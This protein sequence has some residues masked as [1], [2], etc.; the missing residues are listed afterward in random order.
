MVAPQDRL[1]N[2]PQREMSSDAKAALRLLEA[3]KDSGEP[4]R[5]LTS[6]HGILSVEA[7]ELRGDKITVCGTSDAGDELC[8]DHVPVRVF[9]EWGKKKTKEPIVEPPVPPVVVPPEGPVVSP[10][11]TPVSPSTDDGDAETPM[12]TKGKKTTFRAK[13][14]AADIS[15]GIDDRERDVSEEHMSREQ[16]Q[17]GWFAKTFK[18]NYGREIYRQH[19]MRKARAKILNE[20]NMY[21][22]DGAGR[23]AHVKA[24]HATVE[25]ILEDYD[26]F[27]HKDAGEKREKFGRGEA[28]TAAEK[29]IKGRLTNIVKA[30]AADPTMSRE[31]FEEAKKRIFHDA[32]KLKKTGG[33]GRM[34]A[35]NVTEIAERLR[36]HAAHAGGLE[37]VDV[38]LDFVIAKAK[39]GVRTERDTNG[40]DWLLEKMRK[41]SGGIIS[42]ALSNEIAV[43]VGAAYA[44]AA[45]IGQRVALS[46]LASWATFGASA[47]L[48]GLVA[49]Y[50]EKSRMTRERM[51][52]ER[53]RAVGLEVQVKDGMTDK[54][55]EVKRLDLK[56]QLA[57]AKWSEFGKKSDLKKQLA[58]LDR[59]PRRLEME[60]HLREKASAHELTTLALGMLEDR[61]AAAGQALPEKQSLD[62]VATGDV[63]LRESTPEAYAAASSLL[64]EVEARIRLSNTKGVDLLSYSD[65]TEVETERRDLDYARALLKA[66]MRRDFDGIDGI[67]RTTFATFDSYLGKLRSDS[68]VTLYG[69]KSRNVA[70]DKAFSKLATKK[71]LWT[72]T[73]VAVGAMAIGGAVHE[74]VA[75][76]GDSGSAIVPNGVSH[77]D[78]VNGG[79]FVLPEGVTLE[80]VADGS[81]RMVRDDGTVIVD[82]LHAP[83]GLFDAASEAKL[84]ALG[85]H[86]NASVMSID[87]PV[88][89]SRSYSVPEWISAHPDVIHAHRDLWYG[90]DTKEFDLNELKLWWGGEE[91]IGTNANGDILMSM[92]HM[93]PDWSFNGPESTN[94]F[95][96]LAAGKLKLLLSLTEGTQNHPVELDINPDGT[97]VIP[98][99]SDIAKAFFR[100]DHGKP[101][102]LGRFAEIAQ[103]RSVDPTGTFHYG[104]LATYEGRGVTG[105]IDGTITTNESIDMPVTDFDYDKKPHLPPLVPIPVSWRTPLEP[106]GK[107]RLGEVGTIKPR[108]VNNDDARKDLDLMSGASMW[109]TKVPE[110]PINLIAA[111][112]KSMID[113]EEA[114]EEIAEPIVPSYTQVREQMARDERSAA[115]LVER[116][117]N[118]VKTE[119]SPK[120]DDVSTLEADTLINSDEE[121]AVEESV[122][123]ALQAKETDRVIGQVEAMRKS[124]RGFAKRNAEMSPEIVRAW[125]LKILGVDKKADEKTI[126]RA[127]EELKVLL[128]ETQSLDDM[129]RRK[130]EVAADAVISAGDAL[131][132]VD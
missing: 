92:G 115:A 84:E 47:G 24:V 113:R 57:D 43:A 58:A 67:D 33:V 10:V 53:Q 49:G 93:R 20:E 72:G 110:D 50:K 12:D 35:D 36:Q 6:R 99:D 28:E 91:Q 14:G 74:A 31:D 8:T 109:E 96:E 132:G 16:E 80:Q 26:E 88:T 100:M 13:V 118:P 45:F 23:E 15:E 106:M 120:L 71:A 52:H 81:A 11:E 44:G 64:A 1:K 104:I 25:R 3:H 85:I 73:K 54:E 63:R 39:L 5:I 4:I 130:V 41:Y 40:V 86:P 75:F 70:Q 125:Q 83:D 89:T 131:L 111:P 55:R 117:G 60:K 94:P 129:K 9:V 126:R 128:M 121:V 66:V 37:N 27:I 79:E 98:K 103:V 108:M 90:N 22:A 124:A 76:F 102:F 56:K 97:I 123:L 68:E 29:A 59:S 2:E 32:A 107:R 95:S 69:E 17:A 48:A 119:T 105:M 87:N 61:G 7:Y 82:G 30:Y 19:G 18:H 34:Y 112:N 51:L 62:R 116:L 21:A 127:F 101:V 46:G 122:D 77:A 38:E 114:A 65:V 42:D 78:T